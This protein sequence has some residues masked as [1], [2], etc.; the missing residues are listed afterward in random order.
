MALSRTTVKQNG[1]MVGTVTNRKGG[2]NSD[3]QLKSMSSNSSRKST[4]ADRYKPMC[5]MNY[6]HH[7]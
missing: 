7:H 1:K 2:P 6:S 4:Y 3:D 5:G